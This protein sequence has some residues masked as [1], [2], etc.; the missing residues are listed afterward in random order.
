MSIKK[1]SLGIIAVL[2]LAALLAGSYALYFISNQPKAE[3]WLSAIEAFEEQ[4]RIT[5]PPPGAILFVGSSSVVFWETLIP[6][7]HPMTVLNRGFGGSNLSHVTHYAP[8]IIEP[9]RPRAIVIYAGDNDFGGWNPKT[10]TEVLD[11][12][13]DLAAYLTAEL[14]GVPVY[15]LSIKPSLL[16][17][18]EWPQMREANDLIKAFTETNSQLHFIDVSTPMLGEDGILREELFW[19]DGLHLSEA[20]YKLWTSIVRPILM[21]DLMTDETG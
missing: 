1:I 4:D 6:D 5:P 15:Y 11:D 9:Y 16:R 14:P 10:P 17:L 20:G 21:R 2:V 7:M 13:K 8:R 18:E 12:F 19:V 3:Y